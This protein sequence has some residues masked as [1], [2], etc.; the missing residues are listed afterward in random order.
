MTTEADAFI[1]DEQAYHGTALADGTFAI[2]SLRGGVAIIDRAG[3]LLHRINKK[4]GLA[5]DF[6][7]FAYAARNRQLWLGLNYGLS[8][9]DDPSVV[10]K[11][12]NEGEIGLEGFIESIARFNGALYVSTSNGVYRMTPG[13]ADEEPH[14]AA[15]GGIATQCY[16]LLPAAGTLLAA[17]RDGIAQLD[18]DRKTIVDPDFAYALAPANGDPHRIVAAYDNGVGILEHGAGGWKVIARNREAG[19]EVVQIADAGRGELWGGTESDGLYQLQLDAKSQ[20]NLVRRFSTADGLPEAWV[21]PQM[22]EGRLVFLTREG[23]YRREGNRF[24]RDEAFTKA[25]GARPAFRIDRSDDGRTLWLV[26]DNEVL[27]LDRDAGGW[28]LAPT[29]VR[30]IGGGD[31]ILSFLPEGDVVWIG[32]DSGLFRYLPGNDKLPTPP[33]ALIRDARLGSG[34]LLYGGAGSVHLDPIPSSGNTVQF[35]VAGGP[36]VDPQ[37]TWKLDGFDPVWS[38][39]GRDPRKEYTNLPGGHYTFRVAARDRYDQRGP[40][41]TLSF[42]VLAPWFAT[43][44]AIALFA[45]AALLLLVLIVRLRGA[46]LRSRNR[47]LERIIEAKT[48]ELRNA[49]YTDPLTGLRNR[50][51]FADVLA[52]ETGE[53]L[54]LLIDLDYFKSVNDRYGHA[55]GDAV[56]VD[57][58]RRLERVAS[59]HDLLFRWGGEEFLLVVRAPSSNGAQLAERVR[60]AIAS[61]PFAPHSL[62]LTASVGYARFPAASPTLEGALDVADHALYQAKERGRNGAVGV[63]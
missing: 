12:P 1:R 31:R 4:R 8:L 17:T 26:S 3:H 30:G 18:G 11:L 13:S 5:D 22:I 20:L 28:K 52:Q 29:G 2:A 38:A 61:E 53:M 47:E 39:P 46:Q 55:A 56:L 51:Y 10:T 44:W 50:R 41:S 24:V 14:F 60:S 40:E 63:D 35:T 16:T 6:V 34:T 45:T 33:R 25:I 43:W 9:I 49:S 57:T 62:A 32:A 27:R 42:T 21:Y 15:V 23:I 58:A 36:D 19:H 54:L 7:F 59:A 37:L 48:A